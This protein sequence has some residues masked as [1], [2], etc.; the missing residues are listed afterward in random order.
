ML[1]SLVDNIY[2]TRI[3]AALNS[4]TVDQRLE[5]VARFL[6]LT[7]GVD[8]SHVAASVTAESVEREVMYE[9]PDLDP[10]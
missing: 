6:A 3:E 1:P 2:A 8:G 5:K 10:R 4:G 7:A 9:R